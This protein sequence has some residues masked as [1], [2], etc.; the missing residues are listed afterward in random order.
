ML[1]RAE[2]LLHKMN[3]V[4]DELY[5]AWVAEI[6]NRLSNFEFSGFIELKC[7]QLP[8]ISQVVHLPNKYVRSALCKLQ[9]DLDLLGYDYTFK[10]D[11]VLHN[12]RSWGLGYTIEL[13]EEMQ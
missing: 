6:S 12:D 1:P 11:D 2:E 8:N 3:K 10:F 13:P 7:L 4:C 9:N 5:L